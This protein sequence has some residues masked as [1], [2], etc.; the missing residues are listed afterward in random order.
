VVV[1][2]AEFGRLL[3]RYAA[4]L[5]RGDPQDAAGCF[6]EDAVYVGP[7]DRQL[8]RGRDELLAF[9]SASAPAPAPAQR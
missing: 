9:L 1:T 6:T 3:E 7:P 8:Y 4:A 5:N 2:A